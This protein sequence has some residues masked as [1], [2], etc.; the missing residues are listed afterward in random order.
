[1][2][3]EASHPSDIVRNINEYCILISKMLTVKV[4]N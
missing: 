2:S 1:M 4:Y 3:V